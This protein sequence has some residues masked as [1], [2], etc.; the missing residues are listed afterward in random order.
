MCQK[1]PLPDVGVDNLVAD[2]K[3]LLYEQCQYLLFEGAIAHCLAGEM[4]QIH[5]PRTGR[6]RRI[7]ARH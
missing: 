1:Q 3:R 2:G 7:A 5:R 4:G 6:T